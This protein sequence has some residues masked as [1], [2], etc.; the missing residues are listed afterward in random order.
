M[1]GIV[2]LMVSESKTGLRIKSLELSELRLSK[3]SGLEPELGRQSD[4]DSVYNEHKVVRHLT[5][6][7]TCVL[8]IFYS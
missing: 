8:N 5:L 6:L 7:S 3:Q 4:T 2:T 1:H